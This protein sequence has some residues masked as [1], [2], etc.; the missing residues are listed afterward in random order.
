MAKES[1]SAFDKCYIPTFAN[2]AI[3]ESYYKVKKV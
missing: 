3:I 2:V 1:G